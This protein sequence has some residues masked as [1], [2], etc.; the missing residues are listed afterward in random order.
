MVAPHVDYQYC[1]ESAQVELDSG[2]ELV[3]FPRLKCRAVCCDPVEHAM[4]LQAQHRYVSCGHK[5]S[6]Y[7]FVQSNPLDI[8]GCQVRD[9]TLFVQKLPMDSSTIVVTAHHSGCCFCVDTRIN[10]RGNH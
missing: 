3:S 6:K 8:L 1:C 2:N 4:K 9:S 5:W 7:L 10:T